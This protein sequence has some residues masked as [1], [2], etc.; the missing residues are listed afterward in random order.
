MDELPEG[1]RAILAAVQDAFSVM[2]REERYE[3]ID[4]VACLIA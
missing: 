2:V 4:P 3:L 1:I